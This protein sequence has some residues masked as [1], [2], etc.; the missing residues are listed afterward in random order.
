MIRLL[1][2]LLLIAVPLCEIGLFILVGQH[3]GVL[4]TIG[5][6]VLTA[7]IGAALL[8]QQGLAVLAKAQ[9]SMDEGKAPIGP[10]VDGVALLAGG[11]LLLTPGFLTDSIGFV[12][13]IPQAR[14]AIARS[15]F[16]RLVR[17]GNVHV[18]TAGF[19]TSGGNAPAGDT[20]EAD[21]ADITEEDEDDG[22]PP[23]R[24]LPGEESGASPWRRNGADKR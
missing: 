12:L 4:A 13:L 10:V 21:Y 22:A 15:V 2:P 16:E 8:R 17:S 14:A 19:G 7:V 1:L 24:E 6:V 5:L 23:P 9:A 11:L 3:I 18:H 20:I